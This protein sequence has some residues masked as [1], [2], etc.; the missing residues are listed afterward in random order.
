M[1]TRFIACYHCEGE[2]VLKN[3]K[4]PNAKQKYLCRDCG[5]QSREDPGSNAYAPQK[6]EE[7]LNAYQERS[8]L[9]ALTRTFGVSRSTLTRWLKKSR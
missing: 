4:P 5:S 9:R 7:I 1:L 2:N 3:A 8:S 6:P